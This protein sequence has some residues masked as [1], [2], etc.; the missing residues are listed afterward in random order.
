MTVGDLLNLPGWQVIDVQEHENRY[1]IHARP[2]SCDPVCPQCRSAAAAKHGKDQQCLR[3]LP[4]HA[5]HVFIEFSRQRFR[6]L[7]CKKTWFEPISSV[8]ERR[9]ATSRLVHYIQQQSLT[10]T[11]AVIAL[12]C[13][14]DEKSIRNLFHDYV[15]ELERTVQIPTPA[16]M[17]MDELHLLGKARGV[18]TNLESRTFVEVLS[19][20]KKQ[21][22]VH[23]L[24]TLPKKEC[25]QVCVIDMW[26]Q[27]LDAIQEVLPHVTVVID[28]FHVIKRLNEIVEKVRK[29]I[30]S[31]LSEREV[32]QLMH[33]RFLLLKRPC[34]L[35]ERD[36]L[37][38]EGWLGTFPRLKAVYER[39][40]EF[41]AIYDART[42]EEAVQCYFAWHDRI[43]ASGVY[44]D[45]LEFL[46]T[47]EAWGEHIFAYFRHRYTGGFVEAA[48][49]I[50]RVI[51]LQGRGYS[52]EVLRAR[53]L[54]GQR[55]CQRKERT[56]KRVLPD[57]LQ[58][59]VSVDE[60]QSDVVL[61]TLT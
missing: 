26:R 2:V 11:F 12:E 33:D 48:N 59:S 32:R 9:F 42:E 30:R 36:R 8:D 54:Y 46:L 24:A 51:D 38:L 21:T 17:G 6:C 45:F 61:S 13:G 7:V 23:Y 35:S 55:M 22:I 58:E 44:D 40:E 20:R 19:D 39:K 28:K 56:R 16:I 29:D 4:C 27:Y 5:K 50:G 49:G 47:I 57:D 34:D 52:F 31:G 25:V 15:G 10:R 18:I 60:H 14:L 43:V 1:V 3:D 37:I 53:L 41:Y